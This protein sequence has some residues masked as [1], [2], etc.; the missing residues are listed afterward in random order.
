MPVG[1]LQEERGLLREV[2]VRRE[3]SANGALF[4]NRRQECGGQEGTES[5]LNLKHREWMC[6]HQTMVTERISPVS[7]HS[8]IVGS[9]PLPVIQE[10]EEEEEE[11]STLEV[12]L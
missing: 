8:Y 3:G 6:A 9:V 12:A 7:N 11:E 10:E 4:Y 5:P 1:L 2:R